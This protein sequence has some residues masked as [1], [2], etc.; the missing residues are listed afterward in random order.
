M[1]FTNDSFQVSSTNPLPRTQTLDGF[2]KAKSDFGRYLDSLAN[3]TVEALHKAEK[4]PL[5]QLL[6]VLTRDDGPGTTAKSVRQLY[7]LGQQ[8]GLNPDYSKP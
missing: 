8:Y 5:Q 3:R 4:P 7:A 6:L 2:T 1:A